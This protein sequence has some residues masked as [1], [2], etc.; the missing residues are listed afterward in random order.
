MVSRRFVLT[1]FA[2]LLLTVTARV[3]AAAMY[4][5]GVPNFNDPGVQTE[6][7]RV[8]VSRFEEDPDFPVLVLAR[9]TEEPPQFLLVIL[10]ARNGKETWSLREDQAVFYMLLS[11]PGTILQAYLDDGFA[12]GGKPSG[13]FT[14]AGPETV[15]EL[16]AKLRESHRRSRG[17]ARVG[18][19]I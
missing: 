16:I 4:P 17:L 1:L 19:Y 9:L 5:P 15:S 8:A 18:F 11:D 10:D 7:V 6:F 3:T 13:R 14:A 12:S 2:A